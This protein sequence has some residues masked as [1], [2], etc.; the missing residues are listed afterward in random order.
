MSAVEL[1][2]RIL[3]GT[4]LWVWAVLLLLVALGARRLRPKRTHLLVAALAPTAFTV[5]SLSGVAG[6]TRLGPASLVIGVWAAALVVGA[7][8]VKLHR[9]PSIE[10]LGGG[11]FAFPATAVPLLQYLTVFAIRYALGVAAALDPAS[12]FAY[13]FAGVAVSAAT[14]GRFIADFT[15]LLRQ[16]LTRE[17]PAAR[18]G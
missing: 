3:A 6:A 12:A 11:V 18:Q 8:T 4:P 1:A 2:P 10:H 13:G 16:L 5:W 14:A 7:L 15:L 17:R 9:G